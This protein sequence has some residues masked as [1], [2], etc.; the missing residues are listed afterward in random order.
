MV[1]RRFSK[2]GRDGGGFVAIP[3][4]VLD[5][6]AYIGLSLPAKALLMELARQYHGDDNGRMIL[7]RETLARRG[8]KSADVIHRAKQELL[9]AGLIFQTVQ[10]HRPNKASWYALTW[11]VLDRLDGYDPGA[12]AAF[13]RGSYLDTTPVQNPPQNPPSKSQALVRLADK[14]AAL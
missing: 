13:K 3:W 4:V 12:A 1:K 9:D 7:H 14:A 10:G 6:P 8:W 11:L 5:S 2:T